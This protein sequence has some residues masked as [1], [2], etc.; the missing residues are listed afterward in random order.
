MRNDWIFD[1][2]QAEVAYRTAELHKAGRPMRR[3]RW[4]LRR[5]TPEARVPEQRRPSPDEAVLSKAG[6]R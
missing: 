2:V 1:A 5:R 3:R 6:V 4:R